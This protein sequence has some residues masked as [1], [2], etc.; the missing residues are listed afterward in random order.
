MASSGPKFN[1]GS[2]LGRGSG[3][4]LWGGL[5][6]GAATVS[7]S[8]AAYMVVVG[9]SH[10]RF[11]SAANFGVLAHLGPR[12]LP[13][14][15]HVTPLLQGRSERLPMT[16]AA[17]GDAATSSTPAGGGGVDFAPTG[18]VDQGAPHEPAAADPARDAGPPTLKTF[19][20]RD[21]FDDKALVESR[22]GITLVAPGSVLE[23]AGEVL[24]IQRRGDAWVVTTSKGIIAA[25]AH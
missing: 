15:S 10:V 19:I 9:P 22:D 20:L 23:G 25:A 16:A 5:G 1:P 8:F 12:S 13:P 6:V 17:G 3:D 18:S 7:A 21:V 14:D 4:W 24:A 2:F 11:P